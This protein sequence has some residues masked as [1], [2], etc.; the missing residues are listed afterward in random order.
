L[1]GGVTVDVDRLTKP[2]AL[3]SGTVRFSDG[4]SAAWSLDQ[5][6]RLGLSATTPGYK[7]SEGDIVAFQQELR[8]A[9]E[10]MGL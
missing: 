10:K 6:G 5:M 3:A 9:L 7:P 4:V 2:G 1:P 8:S